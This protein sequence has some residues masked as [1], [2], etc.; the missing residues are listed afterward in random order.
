MQKLTTNV[1]QIGGFVIRRFKFQPKH[2]AL[3]ILVSS[4]L[5]AVC[6]FFLMMVRCEP[7]N[8]HSAAGTDGF[9]MLLNQKSVIR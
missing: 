8:L 1:E 7:R 9:E 6:Y 2:V 4:F 3:G 5:T